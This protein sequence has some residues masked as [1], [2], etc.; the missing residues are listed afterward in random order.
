MPVCMLGLSFVDVQEC[1]CTAHMLIPERLVKR[2]FRGLTSYLLPWHRQPCGKSMNFSLRTKFLR[3]ARF[4]AGKHYEAAL[5]LRP[6][7][8]YHTLPIRIATSWEATQVGD[9]PF[10]RPRSFQKPTQFPDS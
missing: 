6:G 9:R 10:S 4:D 8:Y 3:L 2:G 1:E 5:V 7:M